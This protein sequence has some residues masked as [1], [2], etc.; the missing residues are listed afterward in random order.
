M[1]V[2]TDE[3]QWTWMDEGITT[4]V[5][6]KREKDY[7]SWRVSRAILPVIWQALTKCQ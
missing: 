5:P 6:V 1:I 4:T 3:R 7:P 2:N